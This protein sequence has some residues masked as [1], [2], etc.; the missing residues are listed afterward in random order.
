[1]AESVIKKWKYQ[2]MDLFAAGLVGLAMALF[3]VLP[4]GSYVAMAKV[5]GKGVPFLPG[6]R[7]RAIG[8]LSIGF[9]KEKSQGEIR[10]LA[11]EVFY[12]L[13]LTGLETLYAI[14]NPVAY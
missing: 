12:H 7:K 6:Y 8:N 14:A 3:R 13:A 11:K 5:L 2:V 9:G 10:A 4:P 1:M